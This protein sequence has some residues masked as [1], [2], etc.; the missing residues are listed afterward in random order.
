MAE[1]YRDHQSSTISN[2]PYPGT[3]EDT[4][5]VHV[6]CARCPQKNVK[7]L[8]RTVVDNVPRSL[9]KNRFK[10]H[11]HQDETHNMLLTC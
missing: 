7:A 8:T 10:Q 11:E 4:A 5:P 9:F 1:L 2:E 3:I 6:N